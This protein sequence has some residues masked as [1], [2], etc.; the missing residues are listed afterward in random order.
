MG[1]CFP[2]FHQHD[3]LFVLELTAALSIR[4]SGACSVGGLHLS[5]AKFTWLHCN[6]SKHPH[7]I[8]R[9]QTDRNQYIVQVKA[10]L[11]T[12]VRGGNE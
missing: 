9:G 4:T 1:G 8:Q 6:S 7:L 12:A 10:I 2:V 3:F 5:Q 11:I